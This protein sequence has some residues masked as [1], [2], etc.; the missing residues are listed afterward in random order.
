M[1]ILFAIW[2]FFVLLAWAFVYGC[3]KASGNAED[4]FRDVSNGGATVEDSF[5]QY[6]RDHPEITRED[7]ERRMSA[8]SLI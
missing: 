3:S 2:V 1:L 6:L 7:F 8:L 4:P 5:E